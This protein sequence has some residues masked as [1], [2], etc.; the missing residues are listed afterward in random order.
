MIESKIIEPSRNSYAALVFLILSFY[1]LSLELIVLIVEDS[2][3][4]YYL[5]GKIL[6]IYECNQNYKLMSIFL[7]PKWK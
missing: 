7:Y 6:A 5:N 4:S 2:A 3:S 1:L